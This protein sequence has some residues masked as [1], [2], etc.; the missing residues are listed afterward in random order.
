MRQ[1]TVTGIAIGVVLAAA[2]ARAGTHP[3][4]TEPAR[5]DS[6]PPGAL[7]RM[8]MSSSV[9]VLLDEIPAGAARDRAAADA[10]A[11]PESFWVDRAT[12]QANLTYYRLVFRGL[13]YP[14]SWS[15]NSHGKGP[16]PLP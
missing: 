8:Q 13:F 16:L 11:Q 7:V 3:R 12:R 9:A 15:N 6:T 2:W 4:S 10:L 1:S 14:A 5:F